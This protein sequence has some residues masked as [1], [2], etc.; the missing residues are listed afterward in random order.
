VPAVL[1]VAG[2]AFGI[3]GTGCMRSSEETRTSYRSDPEC[4]W[5]AACNESASSESSGYR[6]RTETR[7]TA[8]P[9]VPPNANPGECYGK[10]FIPAKY[11]TRTENVCV[12]EACEKVESIPA[13]YEWV[14][15]QVC[16]KS[17]CKQLVEVP[18][19]FKTVERT[20]EVK[21]GRTEWVVNTSG[22]CK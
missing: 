21:P 10:G 15:E 11:E 18:A 5:S 7:M 1:C 22:K 17:A 2:L 9:E 13:K 3:M 12:K 20:V 14:D 19:E 6:A 16:V 8:T 4:A